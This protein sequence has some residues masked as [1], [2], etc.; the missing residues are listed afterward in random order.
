MQIHPDQRGKV[1]PVG[2][3]SPFQSPDGRF[4][5]WR[6]AVPGGRS[7][8]TPAVAEGRVFL[9]GG[10][11]SFDFFAFDAADGTVAWQY[12]TSDDGPTAAVVDEGH[13][14][15]NTES[16]EIEVLTIDGASVWKRRLGD[17]LM[18]M[19]AVARGRAYQAYPDSK[20]DHGHYLACFDLRTG[21]EIWKQPIGGEVITTPVL[22]GEHVHFAT[23]DGALYRLRQC[24]GR[25]EW[26]E[27][28]NATSSP[29]VW[30]GECY[31]SQ[32]REVT[33]R[34]PGMGGSSQSE[35]LAARAL[36]RTSIR[37]YAATS[38]KADYLDHAK[39]RA[40]SPQYRASEM[41]DAAVGFGAFKGGAE[42]SQAIH[43]L[44]HAHVHA[45]WA[46]QGS[47]PF[48]NRAR[49]YAAQG[50][51]VSAADPRSDGVYWKKSI[52]PRGEEGGDLLDSP[53]TPPA[54]A[55]GKLFFG[56]THGDLLCVSA[57][58]GDLLWG[59]P[60]GEPIVF[61]PAVSRGRVYVGTDA[62]S[63]ICLETGDPGD[64]GW[65]MWGADAAH[66]GRLD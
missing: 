19:P 60:C 8:A 47:K 40:G 26:Q 36:H 32:R 49:L 10:F 63:L 39:R 45:I 48:I 6:V 66:N 46:Y 16:C 4:R 27:P 30:E 31:F 59:V 55:N 65:L 38:R 34:E 13:V 62:G 15:F 18:S 21:Q 52:T 22:A 35:H 17:P 28:R 58:T 24:D 12:Q 64:D 41:A 25:V 44:G 56:T 61:Q 53:L 9:G 54:I 43:N 3:P 37:D 7:L 1:P 50:D 42:I 11:G 29:T 2:P 23:L 14:A 33:D 51:T 57:D 5:G 20:G